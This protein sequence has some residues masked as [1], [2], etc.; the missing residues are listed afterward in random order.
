MELT[1]NFGAHTNPVVS[2]AILP[3]LVAAFDAVRAGKIQPS[4]DSP[5][6]VLHKVD[7]MSFL[8]R[9]PASH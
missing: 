3:Q 8:T 9:A 1:R 6:K 5:G 4:P 2:P 7:D